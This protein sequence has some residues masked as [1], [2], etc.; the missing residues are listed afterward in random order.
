MP[1][2][3]LSGLG[4]GTAPADDDFL[5]YLDTHDTAMA[6]TGTNKKVSLANLFKAL[7]SLRG[8]TPAASKIPYF[9]SGSA[10]SVLTLDTDGTLAANSN[11]TLASQAAVKTYADGKIAKSIGTAKGDIIGFSASGTPVRRAVAAVD[12]K[13]LFADSTQSDGLNYQ[14][15]MAIDTHAN[16]LSGGHVGT[17]L[18]KESDTGVVYLDALGAWSLWQHQGQ[19]AKS[20]DQTLTQSNTTL[21]N[22]TDL[23]WPVEP[24]EVWSWEAI[25]ICV[26]ANATPDIKFGWTTPTS[27]TAGGWW[28]RGTDAGG[29]AVASTPTNITPYSG[30]TPTISVGGRASATE[31]FLVEFCGWIVNGAN[32]G[33]MQLQ[34]SQDVSNASNCKIIKGSVIKLCRQ[35]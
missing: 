3:K 32:A 31:F 28:K 22:L 27:P 9:T 4:S 10:A 16:R 29:V 7:I 11:T 35:A 30:G 2:T 1:D 8:I 5:E 6:G 15:P 13:V 34:A 17:R 19:V 23:V 18:F 12:G 24:S 20:A 14:H 26:T 33:S 25:L 21:Q